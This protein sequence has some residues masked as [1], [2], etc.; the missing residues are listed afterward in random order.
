LELP[1]FGAGDNTRVRR[2]NVREVL[3]GDQL[4]A[5]IVWRYDIGYSVLNESY[6]AV[7]DAEQY[8]GARFR[9]YS[10]SHFVDYMSLAS[11]ASDEYPGPTQHYCVACEDH[12]LDVL[13]TEAPT[14]KRL[15]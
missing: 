15:R 12:I 14:V 11:F 7:D 4:G 5:E 13:S 9:I 10:K 6:A 2:L 8:E 3:L 1:N